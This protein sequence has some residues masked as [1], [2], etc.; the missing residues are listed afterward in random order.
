MS[1]RSLI[2]PAAAIRVCFRAWSVLLRRRTRLDR[3]P[4]RAD[5]G[6]HLIIAVHHLHRAAIAIGGVLQPQRAGLALSSFDSQTR[7]WPH[8]LG[9]SLRS[10]ACQVSTSIERAPQPYSTMKPDGVRL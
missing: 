4:P 5:A 9:P 1:T 7:S 3:I 8:M 10:E 6:H 2:G